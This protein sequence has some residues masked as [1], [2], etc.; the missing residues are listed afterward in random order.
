MKIGRNRIRLL[1]LAAAL[2]LGAESAVAGPF[3]AYSLRAA[4][5]RLRAG[6]RDSVLTELGGMRRI[7]GVVYDSDSKDII[8]VG[9][10]SDEGRITVD[11]LVVALR[12]VMHNTVPLVSIDRTSETATNGTQS[13]RFGGQVENTRFGQDLLDADV[14][15]K[16]LGL[17]LT[18]R[19]LA[20][21]RSYVDLCAQNASAKGIEESFLTR[22]WFYPAQGSLAGRE[23]A[24]AFVIKELRVGVKTEVLGAALNGRPIEPEKLAG[25]RDQMG[26]QFADTLSQ[27]YDDLRLEHPEIAKLSALFALVAV[28]KGIQSLAPKNTLQYWLEVYPVER[29][30]TPKAFPLLKGTEDVEVAGRRRV[31]E[32]EGGVELRTL[33]L[34]L[35]DGYVSAF[36]DVVL[37]ARPAGANRLTWRVPL[38]G[39]HIP[40]T[41][42]EIG[43]DEALSDQAVADNTPGTSLS[44][45]FHDLGSAAGPR[46]L[47]QIV[48]H[49]IDPR[50]AFQ[51]SD[52]LNPQF[53]SSRVGGV[54]LRA[55]A[56]V[57][58]GLPA[59]ADLSRGGFALVVDGKSASLA[60]EAF[61]K[62]VTALWAVYF[63]DEDPGISIDPIGPGIDKH[64]V[65]YIGNVLN[66]DLGR[67]M[68]EADYLMK[69]WAVGTERANV[70]GF[71]N[72]DDFI[73]KVGLQAA[74]YSRFW[75][76][77][78]D[79]TFKRAGDMLLFSGGR[80]TVKTEY[81]SQGLSAHAEPANEKFAEMFTNQY[82]R[83]AESYPVYRELF[84]Y[85]KLVSLAKYLKT[86]GVPLT[87]FL[88]ANKDLVLTEDSPGTVDALAH[89]SNYY[90]NLTITGGVNL[91][92]EGRYV[93]DATATAAIQQAMARSGPAEPARSTVASAP[94]ISPAASQPF[95]FDVGKASYSVIPQHSLT[96]GKDQWG[97]RYQTDLALR[98]GDKPGLE[99]VR[100]FDTR[101]TSQTEF[102]SGWRLLV[103]YRIQPSGDETTEFLNVRVP[104]KMAIENLLTGRN[105][106]LTFSSDRY[107][108]A[109]YVPDKLAASQVVGLFVM[110]N[111]S[112]RLADKLGNE[113]WFDPAG[114]MTDVAFANQERIHYEYLERATDAFERPPYEM[115]PA[116]DET[117]EYRGETLPKR[118]V[119]RN[120]ADSGEET[121][122][123]D[124]TQNVAT[125]FPADEKG[126]RYR[127]LQ[128]SAD[129]GYRLDDK[130][131]NLAGFKQNGQ[132]ES[133]LPNLD[134]SLI[135]SVSMGE[136]KIAMSYRVNSNGRIVIAK[137]TLTNGQHGPD[138]AIRYE[139][140]ADGTLARTERV[141]AKK[142]LAMKRFGAIE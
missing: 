24:G 112:F 6:G 31:L 56:H 19:E 127:R 125:Y 65:R 114:A 104:V 5:E 44:T 30:E 49:A 96:T 84:E 121:L 120:A 130:Y 37:K 88:M 76:V 106:V 58:G 141:E 52:M 95:S 123:F 41:S 61:R 12:A 122:W 115:R 103:P 54:S 28:S 23:S 109:G 18:R 105:E 119:V 13:V 135:Q 20:G 92:T 136:Q 133:L 16:K 14:S 74:A 117:V 124:L 116:G 53:R 4:E 108:I 59:S 102:G 40:G 38:E 47:P 118:I 1:T 35:R 99:L 21:V 68:R 132:F 129:N 62:F 51:F 73:A 72:P 9:Q 142:Q 32:V 79:M 46:S 137:S 140:N 91:K 39:W 85:A 77:P 34:K 36:K 22:F 33:V 26:E 86:S 69:K 50:P 93:Y 29:V 87:W 131:G 100:Y 64:L 89:G 128:W 90:R 81:L 48:A 63:S 98:N 97:N 42:D 60:P 45:T 111:A 101:H 113:F 107:S 75:F 82:D 10:V 78:E 80:M 126:S 71:A 27:G 70:P 67:V 25:V 17:G 57:E 138:L 139:Y 3:V 8:V 43:P 55:E 2:L 66:T 11:D 110:S 94:A 15:L 83:I 7:A 134:S